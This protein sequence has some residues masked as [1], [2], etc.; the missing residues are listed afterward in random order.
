MIGANLP[1]HGFSDK[2]TMKGSETI[3]QFKPEFLGETFLG[4]P[5]MK[6]VAALFERAKSGLKFNLETKKRVGKKIEDLV[7][8]SGFERVLLLL[9]ILHDLALSPEYVL[10]NAEGISFEATLQES[11]KINTIYKHI[12]NNFER[13]IP[14]DEIA[15]EASMTVPAFCRYFKKTTGKT[16]TKMVNEIRIVHASK[17]LSESSSSITDICFECGFNNFSHFNKSFKEFTGKSASRYRSEM[18]QLVQ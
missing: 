14:L 17:L 8:R 16:F 18:K 15:G 7:N 10:L 4:L 6:M 5:E 3:V 2:L 13:P 9:E 11:T 12:K 1:H